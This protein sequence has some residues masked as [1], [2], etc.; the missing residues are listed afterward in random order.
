MSDKAKKQLKKLRRAAT[1][2]LK[3]SLVGLCALLLVVLALAAALPALLSSNAARARAESALAD[4]LKRPARIEAL[5]FSWGDGLRLDGLALGQGGMAD[6]GFVL[7]LRS[8]RARLSPAALLRRDL[9]LDVELRGLRLRLAPQELPAAEATPPAQPPQPLAQTIQQLFDTLGAGLEPSQAPFDAHVSFT[10]DDAEALYVPGS[11]A[12]PVAL[13][14]LRAAMELPGLDAPL[15][16]RAGAAIAG[17]DSIPLALD[18][19]LGP[20]KDAAGLLNPARAPLTLSLTA[21]G[22]SAKGQGSLAEGLRLNADLDLRTCARLAA[23]FAGPALPELDG[24]LAAEL[25]ASRPDAAHAS[26]ALALTLDLRRASGGPLKD[27]S[28]GPLRLALRQQA[29]VDIPARTAELP[30]EL[31]IQRRGGMSWTARLS[32]LPEQKPVLSLD[33]PSL[34]LDLAELLPAVAAFL[35]PGLGVSGGELSAS[36]LRAVLPLP[37]G[38]APAAAASVEA[39]LQGL[40]LGLRGLSRSAGAERLQVD[41]LRLALTEFSARLPLAEGVAG[42]A[43]G[44]LTLGLQAELSGLRQSRGREQQLSVSRAQVRRVAVRAQGLR[45]DKAALFGLAG[46]ASLEKDAQVEGL[47]AGGRLRVPQLTQSVRADIA[48]PADK[49]INVSLNELRLEAPALRALAPGKPPLVVPLRLSVSAPAISLEGPALTPGVEGLR[50]E[51]RAGDAAQAEA[52]VDLAGAGRELSTRGRL[53]ADL[54]RLLALAAPLLPAKAKGSGGVSAQW[55]L[56]ATLPAAEAAAARPGVASVSKPGGK[57]GGKA[58]AKPAPEKLLPAIRK[59]AFLHELE[60]SLGLSNLSLDWPLEPGPGQKPETLRLRGLS[61]PRPLRLATRDGLGESSLAGSLAFGPLDALPGAGKLATPVR[62]L[63]TVDARQQG[64]RSA[65]LSQA[66]RLDGFDLDQNLALSLDRLDTLLARLDQGETDTL[67][68]ALELVDATADFRLA[69]GLHALPGAAQAAGLKAAR[70]RL[71]AAAGLRLSAGRSLTV[72]ARLDSPG[73]DLRLGQDLA[74]SGLASD[75]RFSRRYSMRPGL[76]CPGGAD[77]AP[78]PL[79]ELV[80]GRLPAPGVA[81]ELRS[82]TAAD[83]LG[84]LLRTDAQAPAASGGIAF[85]QLRLKGGGLP[86]TL[87]DVSLRL[88]AGS[89]APGLQSFRAGLLGGDVLGSAVVRKG[90]PGYLL[91]AN[92]AFTGIDPSRLLPDKAPRDLAGQAETSGRLSVELP[93]TPDPEQLLQRLNLRMDISK[94]GPRT[95]ERMLY[96]LDPDE[97]NEAIV[98]QRRLMGM[99]YP[100]WLRVAAAYGNLS[101]SGAV[102]VKG[103]QLDLPQ[104]D[105]LGLANL[106]VRKQLE[107]PLAGVPAL[108]R[109]LDAASGSVICRDTAGQA[110]A[111]TYGQP[112]PKSGLRVVQPSAHF[113]AP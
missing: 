34:R 47:D 97:Q 100:R 109:A 78:A 83:A 29:L 55:R 89:P 20:L 31:G 110:D 35:P 11:Q 33:A 1:R 9:L 71:E 14:D 90:A 7:S 39:G 70:G 62:G 45:L 17:A 91:S 58:V 57:P 36:G 111:T 40:E 30:G 101:V 18:A 94:I 6:P 63:F 25:S 23:R 2:A 86:L 32:G 42:S 48:L 75:L 10:L 102:D 99:G 107:K 5:A 22:L 44:E 98:Q 50:V 46:A 76:P 65:Q 21:P 51:L 105:R 104:V 92:L 88:D 80:V 64:A 37:G 93:L 112:A 56:A 77:E 85:T 96:A 28:A 16:L 73:L 41:M 15:S 27:K 69:S 26:A 4:A 24:S 106:P 54:D 84:Q 59:L 19:R 38:E 67:A 53:S 3:W 52:D 79:S 108:I 60:A 72:S 61:T 113:P 13:A 68:A 8:L 103:F 82:L 81:P 95:L 43:A 49:R 87:R 12:E 74:V 66:L